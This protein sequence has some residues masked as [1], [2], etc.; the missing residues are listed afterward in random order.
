M[1]EMPLEKFSFQSSKLGAKGLE[2]LSS[3]LKEDSILWVSCRSLP[4]KRAEIEILKNSGK[5]IFNILKTKFYVSFI[6]LQ[7][8]YLQKKFQKH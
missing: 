8:Y 1:D 4:N 3:Y 2:K 7:K 6:Q 5:S